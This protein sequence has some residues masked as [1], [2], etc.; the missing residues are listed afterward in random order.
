MSLP[1]QGEGGSPTASRVWVNGRKMFNPTPTLALPLT[2][3]GRS[4]ALP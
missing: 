1:L 3:G 2:V 4:P